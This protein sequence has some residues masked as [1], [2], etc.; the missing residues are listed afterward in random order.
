MER[1]LKKMSA[2]A[3]ATILA[4]SCIDYPVYAKAT[5]PNVLTDVQTE[6]L[7]IG[8]VEDLIK[9]SERVNNGET[10]L[11][12]ILTNDIDMTGEAWKAI[13]L[14]GAYKG[15]F[16][17]KGH[18][19]SNLTGGQGL[20]HDNEGTI[21]NIYVKNANISGGDGNIGAIAG[22]NNGSIIGCFSDG[23]I[24]GKRYSIG[25]I[26]GH[27]QYGSIT[28]C[29]SFVKVSGITA[30]GLIGSNYR[31]GKMNASYYYGDASVE[32]DRVYGTA[33]DVYFG[34]G[35]DYRHYQGYSSEAVGT[36]TI[37]EKINKVLAD[38]GNYF[39]LDV[40]DNV[41]KKDGSF[42]IK[43]PTGLTGVYGEK[44]SE[45]SLPENWKWEDK[46]TV[47]KVGEQS[48]PAMFDTSKYED[49]Y[50][51]KDV[52]GYNPDGK[53]ASRV[54]TVNAIKADSSLAITT[55]NMNKEYDGNP[56][57]EPDVE[58]IGSSKDVSFKWYQKDE[59]S[60]KELSNAPINVGSYKVVAS[61]DSDENYNGA[62]DEK[63]FEITKSTPTYVLPNNLF[64]KIGEALS[65]LKLPDG[66]AWKDSTQVAD[67]LGENTFD[68]ILTP[69]DT[70]NYK[71]I[72]V[73]IPVN[74]LPRLTVVNNIP[75]IAANDRTLYVGDTFDVMYGVIAID[76]EDG[77]IFD[78]IEVVSNDVD[79][80]KPGEYKVTYKVSDNQGA[81]S[82][83][84][85]TITVKEKEITEEPDGD[86]DNE[87]NNSQSN[88]ENNK[89]P[90]ADN[91]QI[92][93]TESQ[94]VVKTSDNTNIIRWT[95][96][97]SISGLAILSS[98][99]LERRKC[100]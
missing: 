64:I 99:L 50:Y 44:L 40:T 96:L 8:S 75:I 41:L 45:V 46:D 63:T 60:W 38:N 81:S 49:K 5:Q 13:G 58:K 98:V 21:K 84:T 65:S 16:D 82:T 32:G 95:V 35:T 61:V 36:A 30:G 94:D 6:T 76:V 77:F 91:G 80:L 19:V 100:N 2:F 33:T 29:V 25:G 66:F 70:E 1:K 47:L 20:F 71:T 24:S 15:T 48:Y 54:L 28:G 18:T 68:A 86:K 39:K 83:K 43:E 10:S 37:E 57:N 55:Q 52:E 85:V 22:H 79:T 12:G 97:L 74:V 72:E 11:D 87:K 59:S 14:N 88:G 90:Q 23:S 9:F 7:S 93:N 69:D 67:K 78:K 26:A 3:L 34:R 17:G 31:N 51:F 92:Q 73:G 89:T 27:N 56:I 62:S 53:Y 4:L 42:L